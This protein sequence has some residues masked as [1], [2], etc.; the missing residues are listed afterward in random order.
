MQKID[1]YRKYSIWLFLIIEIVGFVGILTSQFHEITL[2]LSS[3]NLW[4]VLGFLLLHH[5]QWNTKEALWMV[6]VFLVGFFVEVAGVKTGIIFGEYHYGE[7]LGL[8]IFNVPIT[9]GVNWLLM[10]Y[11]SVYVIRK[12]KL[13]KVVLGLIA[14]LIMV[15]MDVIMEPV[16]MAFDFWQWQNNTVPFRNYVAWFVIASILNTIWFTLNQIGLNIMAKWVFI[17]LI[18]FFI[19]MFLAF[20]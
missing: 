9:M 5:K 7:T 8:K 20:A 2:G 14:A 18:T 17:Y 12:I 10:C 16:A 13:P 6:L 1:T 19:T 11:T 15:V 3:V 4:F